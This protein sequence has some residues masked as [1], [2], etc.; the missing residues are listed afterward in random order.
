MDEIKN[1]MKKNEYYPN[2]NDNNFQYK[3]FSKKEFIN[4]KIKERD[5]LHDY[6]DIK[7]YRD[8][9]C[10]GPYK[11]RPQQFLLTNYMNPDTPYK[12]LLMFHGVGTGKCVL[13]GTKVYINDN[14]MDIEQVWEKYSTKNTLIYDNENGVWSNPY[15]SLY[16]TSIDINTNKIYNGTITKLYRQKIKEKIN[17]IELDNGEIIKITKKHKLLS[18]T[19]W[20]SDFINNKFILSPYKIKKI[21]NNND[22]DDIL[23]YIYGYYKLNSII[24]KQDNTIEFYLKNKD[25]ILILL[26]YIKK[27]INYENL[28]YTINKNDDSILTLQIINKELIDKLNIIDNINNDIISDNI[29]KLNKEKLKILL[30]SIFDSSSYIDIDEKYIKLEIFSNKMLYQIKYLLKL[31]KIESYLILNELYIY[32]DLS[33]YNFLNKISYNN[34]D[35]FIRLNKIINNQ[36]IINNNN[37]QNI[38]LNQYEEEYEGYVYD[39]EVDKYHNYV[40]NNIISH[41]TCAAISIA[42]NFKNNI[43]RYDTKIYILVPGSIIKDNWMKEIIKCSDNMN[44]IN[45]EYNQENIIKNM[46]K[47]YY[48]IISYKSFSK[49]VLG[50]KIIEKK[51]DDTKQKI[52]KS[53]KV[54]K[55]GEYERDFGNNRIYSLD[56]T[57]LIIDEAHNITGNEYGKAIKKIIKKSKNLRILLLS[58]T[59]MKNSADEIVELL[60][61]IRPLNDQMQRDKIF[62]NP[63]YTYQLEIKENG[64]EYL[65]EKS[66]GIVSYFRGNDPLLFAKQ[67][68]NGEIL[69]ELLFTKLVRCKMMEFQKQ[70]INNIKEIKSDKLDKNL[71]AA[72]NF[73]FPILNSKKDEIIGD[74]SNG[75]LYNIKN[76]I[77]KDNTIYID[78]LYNFLKSNNKKNISKNKLVYI[79]NNSIRGDILKLENLDIFSIKFY[80]ILNNLNNLIINKKGNKTA[81]I[82]S[83]LVKVGVDLFKNILLENGYLEYDE[84]NNYQ[85]NNNTVDYKYGI[86]SS[87]FKNIY[88]DEIFY[89]AT[90]L[91]ITGDKEDDVNMVEYKK[92]I[93]DNIFNKIENIDG[94]FIKLILGSRVMNEGTTLENVGEVHILD[95]YYNLGK[96]YQAIG[97]VMRQCKHYKLIDENNKYPNV[98]VYRYVISD[99]KITNEELLYKKAELKYI[100]VKKVEKILKESALDCPLLY[101]GNIFPEEL[102]QYE[103]CVPIDEY[104]KLNSDERKK[105]LLCPEICNY[106]KCYYKCYDN[107]SNKDLDNLYDNNKITYNKNK[108]I[109]DSTFNINYSKYEL[110]IIKDTIKYLFKFKNY[111]TLKEIIKIIPENKLEFYDNYFV[112]K[113]LDS[114]IPITENDFNNFNDIIYNSYNIPG[115]LIYRDNYY[116]YQPFNKNEDISLNERANYKNIINTNNKTINDFLNYI[117]FKDVKN[118]STN[119]NDIYNETLKYYSNKKNYSYIGYINIINGIEVFKI[120]KSSN[121][122]KNNIFNGIN[123]SSLDKK[124]LFEIIKFLKID[125]DIKKNSKTNLCSII[126]NKLFELEKFS[127][128]KNNNKYTYL[129]IPKNLSNYPFPLNIEDRINYINNDIKIYN[130]QITNND[131]DNNMNINNNFINNI[132]YDN[133]VKILDKYHLTLKNNKWIF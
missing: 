131:I 49:K 85:I 25:E 123:C 61:Y 58:A 26:N 53:Y 63:Q 93:I 42:D 16:T 39:F 66:R 125:S 71:I 96:I 110:N 77:E 43:L 67:I 62:D 90:F 7:L 27:I 83:N 47:Q 111:Y 37:R 13:P 92:N 50:E 108:I 56:N 126:K 55:K 1:L 17:V 86:T 118:T 104:K 34:I 41:N 38:I 124:E 23:V 32:D 40:I 22:I 106:E 80:T 24:N 94:K 60:N 79:K 52:V 21:F 31:F 14:I 74:Y 64:L 44:T 46:I 98:D 10:S 128:L 2:I 91:I 78:K 88:K 36:T 54:N 11:L 112:Y 119:M 73:I 3:I 102:K 57:L 75:G 70:I 18:N 114:M 30:K 105:F 29:L 69:D 82:Y 8:N 132:N 103:K 100:T 5:I 117:N 51:Y 87:D 113:S 127:S 107:T 84:K 115:Y 81:F 33:I 99:N 4:R 95:A 45:K 19:G 59:P 133:I 101:N 120:I 72:S 116:I 121:Y 68:D 97:R 28:I 12:G 122:D 89:P 35:N 48:K 15:I 65:R 20:T 109:D 130:I 9:N 76:N 129:I 6:K